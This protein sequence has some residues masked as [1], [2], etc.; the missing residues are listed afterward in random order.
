MDERLKS[1]NERQQELWSQMQ[2]VGSGGFEDAQQREQYE[3]LET[4]LGSVEEEIKLTE[5]HLERERKFAD[6]P[7]ETPEAPGVEDERTDEERYAEAYNRYIRFGMS[8]LNPDER[9]LLQTRAVSHDQ[10]FRSVGGLGADEKRALGTVQGSAGGFTVPEGFWDQIVDARSAFGG[11]RNAPV[12][13]LTTGDGAD[14][15]I[16][17]GDDDSSNKGTYLG[18][19]QQLSEQDLGFDQKNL[20]A[21]TITSNIVRVPIQLLQDS[22]FDIEAYL[23]GKLGERI[24]RGEAAKFAQGNGLQQPE[25][26]VSAAPV[27]YTASGTTT[28]VYGDFVQLVHSVDP[29]YRNGPDVGFVMHDDAV[30][31]ARLITVSS[32]DSRP[33][34]QPG[35][36]PGEPSTIL[37]YSYTIDNDFPTV[38]S[39]N[40]PVAFGA[41]S[42]YWI[43]DVQGMQMMRLSERYADYLQVGF[44]AF[45]RNDGR[46]IDAGTNPIKLMLM[47]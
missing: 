47:S 7:V 19:N 26:L 37:G 34:W 23:A 35:M 29:A 9:Q 46:L 14:I 32:T 17:T 39:S 20:K 21:F 25:G 4:E 1:L 33:L 15:P 12:F 38:A 41:L 27:G 43:R 40:K 13:Q 2:E 30:K 36:I 28:F 6:Q 22:A 11:L 18:E 5:R 42:N 31:A 10:S 24:G 44:L 3:K 16:P 45:A 8:E